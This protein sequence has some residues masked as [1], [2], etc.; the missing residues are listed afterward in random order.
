MLE[1]VVPEI[2]VDL[3]MGQRLLQGCHKPIGEDVVPSR[4]PVDGASFA[5]GFNQ[6]LMQLRYCLRFDSS[7]S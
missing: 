3:R 2:E 5:T 6:Y 1:F 4:P 7:N